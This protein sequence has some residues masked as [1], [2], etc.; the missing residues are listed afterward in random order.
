MGEIDYTLPIT[1]R[2]DW[3]Y[4]VTKSGLPYHVTLN[5]PLYSEVANY[6]ANNPG[7]VLPDA[8][9]TE[10]APAGTAVE[11]AQETGESETAV[12]SQKAVT[13]ALSAIELTPGEGGQPGK[14]AYEIAVEQGFTGTKAQWLASLKG[15]DGDDGQPGQNGAAATVTIGTVTTGAAGSNAS[16]TKSGTTSAAVLNFTIP[17]GTDGASYTGPPIGTYATLAAATAA[18]AAFP[19][20]LCFFPEE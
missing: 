1:V 11:I 20:K 12:M 6:S 15:A 17:K 13:D 5:D 19:T 9:F 16:V 2:A 18:S 10:P 3:S 8:P 14:S 7:S 4:V